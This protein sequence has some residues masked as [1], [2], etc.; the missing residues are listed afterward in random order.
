[1]GLTSLPVMITYNC[2]HRLATGVI[3]ASGTLAQLIPPSL[4]LI[5]LASFL[6]VSVDELFAGALVPGIM[7]ATIYAIYAVVIAYLRPG[8]APPIPEEQRTLRGWALAADALRSIVP[9]ILLVLAVLGSI[10][11][12]IATASEAGAVRALGAVLLALG[13]RTL[14]CSSSRRPEHRPVPGRP[15]SGRRVSGR[16]GGGSGVCSRTVGDRQ[17]AGMTAWKAGGRT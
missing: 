4:V 13:C 17:R 1:M 5:V 14:S 3:T 10:F 16:R 6:P 12:G 9:P 11:L 7:L 8:T 2:N 15:V